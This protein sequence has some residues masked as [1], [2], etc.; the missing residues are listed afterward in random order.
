MVRDDIPDIAHLA[1][2]I[3]RA[4]SRT[5]VDDRRAVKAIHLRI[6]EVERRIDRYAVVRLSG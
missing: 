6:E 4:E 1:A 5:G 2:G 3:V